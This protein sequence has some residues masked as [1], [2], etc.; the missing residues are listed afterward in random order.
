MILTSG[1]LKGYYTGTAQAAWAIIITLIIF[2]PYSAARSFWVLLDNLYLLDTPLVFFPQG[3]A[4]LTLYYSRVFA[5]VRARNASIIALLEPTSAVVFAAIILKPADHVKR[6]GGRRA[7][8]AWC[9]G[10]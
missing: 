2:L 9:A 3:F 6:A 4:S 5:Y 10:G 1:Y 8:T 7:D